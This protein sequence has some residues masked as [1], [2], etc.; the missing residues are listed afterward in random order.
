MKRNILLDI[1]GVLANFYSGFSKYLNKEFNLELD[2]SEDPAIY[3]IEAWGPGLENIDLGE[4]SNKWISNGGFLTLETYPG[5]AE[6]VQNL[7][8]IGNVYIVTARI[9]DWDGGLDNGATAKAKDDTSR[10]L[11]ENGIPADNLFFTHKKVDFCKNKNIS[12]LIEDKLK[13][14]LESANNGIHSIVMNRGWNQ[15]SE[16]FKVYRAHSYDDAI[17]LVKKISR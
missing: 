15:H 7:R 8:D 2:P 5:A 13:T 9:G 11:E 12:I 6:F 14:A 1:D 17:N 3:D 4:V 10:W 16:R